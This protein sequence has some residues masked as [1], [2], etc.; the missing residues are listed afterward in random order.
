MTI[1]I[2]AIVLG[3]TGVCAYYKKWIF[4]PSDFEVQSLISYILY[5]FHKGYTEDYKISKEG[6]KAIKSGKLY[7]VE[8]IKVVD[9][10]V[11][12]SSIAPGDESAFYAI[13]TDDGGK[14]TL[15]DDYYP[16][17]QLV[18]FMEKLTAK[19]KPKTSV[20]EKK[21]KMQA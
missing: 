2:V 20:S 12:D 14:G 9:F 7:S 21:V 10:H 18:K 17:S 15:V 6:M 19:Q 13:E 8:Q 16:D 11:F 1:V 4:K 3:C 5:F